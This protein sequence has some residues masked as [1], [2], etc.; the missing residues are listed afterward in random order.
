MEEQRPK[1]SQ[2]ITKLERQLWEGLALGD[3]DD[4]KVNFR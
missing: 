3:K 2:N 1:D 4:T